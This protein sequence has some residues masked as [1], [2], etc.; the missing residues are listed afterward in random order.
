[1]D[2]SRLL[3]YYYW[4]QEGT[5]RLPQMLDFSQVSGPFSAPAHETPEITFL[6]P[7]QTPAPI[8]KPV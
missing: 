7:R 4:S 2:W 3:N 8:T 6:S 1:M 5:R